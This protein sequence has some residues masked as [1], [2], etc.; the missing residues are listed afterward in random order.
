MIERARA[1]PGVRSAGLS[2]FGNLAGASGSGCCFTTDGFTPRNRQD[3]Q[4][5]L[6][7]VS[8]GYFQTLGIPLLAGR[9]FAFSDSANS[10]KVAIIN[11]TMA[12]HFFGGRPAI[13]RRLGWVKKEYEV[14]GVVKDSKY[15]ELREKT[16]RM[17][18]FSLNQDP[19]DLHRLAVSTAVP[20]LNVARPVREA[21]LGID[22]RLHIDDVTTLS[23]RLDAKLAREYLLA[24]LSGFFSGLTL[25]LVSIG[26]YGTLAYAVAR[27]TSEIGIRMALGARPA[28]VQ[29]MILGDILLVLG[30]GL[31]AGLGATLLL[32]RSVSSLLFEVKPT[33]PWTIG[34][35]AV[36]LSAVALAAGY[37]PARRAS[38]VDPLTALRAE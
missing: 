23:Q 36:L 32:M 14:I 29:R 9:D 11:E 30:A 18:Y 12:R 5:A 8:P 21:L 7:Y 27:R 37:L 38:Q 24:D 20:P 31:V 34:G 6:D 28:A 19:H 25:L 13:G 15:R 10:Q 3:Q 16:P 2:F 33:D 1:V 4:A 26:I 22:P 17:I 35:A